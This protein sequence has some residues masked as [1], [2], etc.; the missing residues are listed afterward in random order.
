MQAEATSLLEFGALLKISDSQ[1]LVFSMSSASLRNGMSKLTRPVVLKPRIKQVRLKDPPPHFHLS[2][3]A[4][5]IS[6]GST[7]QIG[8]P[9]RLLLDT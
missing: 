5:F 7:G 4:S 2:C 3:R 1:L 6:S 8:N 9:T